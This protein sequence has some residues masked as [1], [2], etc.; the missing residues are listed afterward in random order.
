MNK[1]QPHPAQ[2]NKPTFQSTDIK[3]EVKTTVQTTDLQVGKIHI[4]STISELPNSTVI[5]TTIT[6]PRK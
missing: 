2:K 6:L 4:A 1:D 5:T 3:T